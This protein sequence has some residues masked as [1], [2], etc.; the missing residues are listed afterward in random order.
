MYLETNSEILERVCNPGLYLDSV[1][2]VNLA[3][4]LH[5]TG[6]LPES[7]RKKFV[8]KISSYTVNGD[9][10]YLFERPALRDIFKEEEFVKL[11]N[12]TRI[13]LI[14]KL[15]ELRGK[16]ESEFKREGSAEDYIDPF[17]DSLK[18]LV[19]EFAEDEDLTDII[20]KEIQ[21]AEKWAS[22]NKEEDVEDKS[23]V[24][25]GD[26]QVIDNLEDSRSVFD[27]I[28]L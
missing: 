5:E 15:D 21:L 23:R 13:K 4:R 25:L 10:L 24:K 26:I 1:F 11:R 3:L 8:A 28:D 27:D 2:E 22:D 20:N 12:E 17:L 9:D 19:N 6:L 14:P 7:H 18:G 16:W